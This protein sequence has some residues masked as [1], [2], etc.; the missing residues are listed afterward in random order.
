[1][2]GW[3]RRHPVLAYCLAVLLWSVPW[4]AAILTVVP[5]GTTFDLSLHPAAVLL[6]VVRV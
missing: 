6:S 5:I 2:V 1:M 4:W 3:L